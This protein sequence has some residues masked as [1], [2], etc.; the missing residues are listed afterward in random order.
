MDNDNSV[1]PTRP[2]AKIYQVTSKYYDPEVESEL[3]E[4]Q[5]YA[6]YLAATPDFVGLTDAEGR[7]TFF[8]PVHHVYQVVATG[9]VETP[10]GPVN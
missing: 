1:E 6:G 5:T 10:S 2:S 9:D 7:V 8:M 3:F 4:T